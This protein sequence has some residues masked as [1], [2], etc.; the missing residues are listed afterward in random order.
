ML[1]GY[2]N[3]QKFVEIDPQQR[4]EFAIARAEERTTE[5]NKALLDEVKR[6]MIHAATAAPTPA[7]A[8]IEQGRPRKWVFTAKR[9]SNDLLQSIDAKESLSERGD[10]PKGWSFKID[11]DARGFL[12]KVTAEAK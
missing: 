2:A 6:L 10:A 3:L 9:G 5:A 12:T 1:K 7:F 11:R 8:P 4:V